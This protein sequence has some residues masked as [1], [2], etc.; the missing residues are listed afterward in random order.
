MR[1]Q[2]QLIL[3]DG[4]PLTNTQ[5]N[6]LDILPHERIK[7]IMSTYVHSKEWTETALSELKEIAETAGIQ[8]NLN[9]N[10][11]R[12]VLC[13]Y[14]HK[15]VISSTLDPNNKSGAVSLSKST[16]LKSKEFVISEINISKEKLSE[17]GITDILGIYGQLNFSNEDQTKFAEENL[18]IILESLTGK[19]DSVLTSGSLLGIGGIGHKLA[20]E[21]DLK[22]I[23]IIPQSVSFKTN[24]NMFDALLV[25]GEDWGDGSFA[26]GGIATN[27]IFMGGGYWSFLEYKYGHYFEKPIKLFQNPAFRYSKEFQEDPQ[28]HKDMDSNLENIIRCLSNEV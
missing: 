27:I 20:K 5:E 21:K 4:L 25:Q 7:E 26:F 19:I 10:I 6:R 2:E 28:T 11:G 16:F 12:L 22:T 17:I 1:N 8:F 18:G 3:I 9:V 24:P 23:G 14:P 15:L 13:D